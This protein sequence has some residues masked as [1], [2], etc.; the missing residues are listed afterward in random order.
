MHEKDITEKALENCN[1]VFAEYFWHE[2]AGK[3]YEGDDRA[4]EHPQEV[5]DLLHALTKDN[6][7]NVNVENQD[8]IRKSLVE[9]GLIQE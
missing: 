9:A 4:L 2:A 1:D 7:F 8:V 3:D 5:V 6:R